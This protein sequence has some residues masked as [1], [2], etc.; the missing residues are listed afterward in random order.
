[1]SGAQSSE[2]ENSQIQDTSLVETERECIRSL[3]LDPESPTRWNVLALVYTMTGKTKRAKEAITNSLELNTSNAMTWRIWGDLL[4]GLGQNIESERTYRMSLELDPTHI[5]TMH[6]LVQL[7]IE[8][9]AYPE[10]MDVLV[11]LVELSPNDQKVWDAYSIS[12][13]NMIQ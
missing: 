7:L 12:L 2:K 4:K 13:G 5:V 8:R 10:A 9:N 11:R 1:M 3:M 6:R